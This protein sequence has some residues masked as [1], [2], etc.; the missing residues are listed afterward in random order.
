MTLIA[1]VAAGCWLWL[2]SYARVWMFFLV[3]ISGLPLVTLA[4]VIVCGFLGR[5]DRLGPWT[6]VVFVLQALAL[7]AAG[8]IGP[9]YVDGPATA[10]IAMFLGHPS[11]SWST[12]SVL[13]YGTLGLYGVWLLL[14][15]VSMTLAWGVERPDRED[16]S[17]LHRL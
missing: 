6:S 11:I 8:L 12:Y 14:I 17:V 16:G 2:L 13:E 4:P 9:S 3:T 15:P 7:V 10:P 5:R 1:L